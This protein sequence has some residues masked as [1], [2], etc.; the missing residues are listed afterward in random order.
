MDPGLDGGG[1]HDSL[2][3]VL[4]R[5]INNKK[6]KNQFQ[7]SP[8]LK[9]LAVM[10]DGIPSFQLRETFGP[11]PPITASRF[12]HHVRLLRRSVGLLTVCACRAATIER[13]VTDDGSL[14]ESLRHRRRDSARHCSVVVL[15]A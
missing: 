3:P 7:D 1:G 15:W 9:W 14:V 5:A 2:V 10:L 11:A 13:R 8:G 12:G 4:Q 6:A